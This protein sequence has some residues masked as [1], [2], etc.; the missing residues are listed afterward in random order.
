MVCTLLLSWL[1]HRC[2][3]WHKL[4]ER[5]WKGLFSNLEELWKLYTKNSIGTLLVDYAHSIFVQI[6]LKSSWLLPN[7]DMSALPKL[8][9]II[10]HSSIEDVTKKYLC[11]LQD[12][13]DTEGGQDSF[14]GDGETFFSEGWD[15]VRCKKPMTV[16]NLL[17]SKN[18]LRRGALSPPLEYGA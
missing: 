2:P 9:T 18:F 12:R 16:I 10:A 13:Q 15:V 17:G 6:C 3:T 5:L 11:T 14:Q 4:T 7:K 8:S 1:K